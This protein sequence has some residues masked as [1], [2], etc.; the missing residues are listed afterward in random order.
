[1]DLIILVTDWKNPPSLPTQT[2]LNRDGF[3]DSKDLFLFQEDWQK[4]L[5]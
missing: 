5:P 2:D 4:S 3:I 1:V